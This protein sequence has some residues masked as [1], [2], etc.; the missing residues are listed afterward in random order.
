MWRLSGGGR[1]EGEEG[2]VPESEDPRGLGWTGLKWRAVG[3]PRRAGAGA[4]SMLP[5][6][7]RDRAFAVKFVTYG[8]GLLGARALAAGTPPAL[9]LLVGAS[10]VGRHH[11]TK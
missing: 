2:R 9:A 6:S 10:S 3:R 5:E 8:G 1:R 4:G 7:P 11:A